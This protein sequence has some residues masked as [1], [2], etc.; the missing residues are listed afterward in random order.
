MICACAVSLD[1]GTM[2]KSSSVDGLRRGL[3]SSGI[4]NVPMAGYLPGRDQAFKINQ[5]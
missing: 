4:S 1:H 2:D 5:S 3:G